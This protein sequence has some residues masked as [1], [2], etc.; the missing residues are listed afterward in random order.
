MFTFHVSYKGE[1]RQPFFE[2]GVLVWE[3]WNSLIIEMFY[4][5]KYVL[6]KYDEE[7]IETAK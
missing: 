4:N 2:K 6:I 1:N 3:Q 5:M 7:D